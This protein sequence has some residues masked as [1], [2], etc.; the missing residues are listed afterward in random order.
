MI[1][2]AEKWLVSAP[3]KNV[4]ASTLAR[5]GD[6]SLLAWFGGTQ[7]GHEDVD[8]YM[9]RISERGY[10]KPIMVAGQ[11]H[12]PHWNPVLYANGNRIDLFYKVGHEIPDWHT[13]HAVSLDGG[14]SFAPPKTLVVGDV[15]GRG[16]VRNKPIRLNS[17][18][19]LAPASIE[20]GSAWDAFVDITSE[21][22]TEFARSASVPL[23]RG[24]EDAPHCEG[25]FAP[26]HVHG[27]G[28][29]QPTLWQSEDQSVHMLLRSTEGYILRSDSFDEGNSWCPAYSI[30]LPNNNSGIDLARMEDGLLALVLNP[31]QGNWAARTPLSLY[32]SQDDGQSFVPLMN[33]EVTSGEYSYP[34]IVTEGKRLFLSYTWKRTHIAYWQIELE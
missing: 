22:F 1:Q 29:I 4:H 5:V 17:G 27:K 3:T 16:P 25:G 9:T 12:C 11:A 26:Q 18:R 34:A 10:S 14:N 33:F 30:G 13:R 31:V 21:E 24:N 28:E 19:V 8:I 7:E 23:W 32:I 6:E 15:G 20:A 2:K